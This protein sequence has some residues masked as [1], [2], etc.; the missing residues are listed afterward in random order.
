MTVR[1]SEGESDFVDNGVEAEV[2]VQETE[3]GDGMVAI[4]GGRGKNR[5]TTRDNTPG[6][7]AKTRRWSGRAGLTIVPRDCALRP[8]RL[9]SMTSDCFSWTLLPQVPITFT[10]VE[11]TQRAVPEFPHTPSWLATSNADLSLRLE[12]V[13]SSSLRLCDLTTM[14]L[15]RVSSVIWRRG[16]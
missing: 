8:L 6:P 5:G 4:A 14:G 15:L 13:L 7:R 9:R 11:H 3:D 12:H 10:A 16:S 2:K 1:Q